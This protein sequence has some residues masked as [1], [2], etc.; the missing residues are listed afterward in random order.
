MKKIKL[1]S[2]LTFFSIIYA[3][4]YQNPEII[5][6]TICGN[7]D[8][9]KKECTPTNINMQNFIGQ[10]ALMHSCIHNS[11]DIFTFLMKNNVD[12]NIKDKAGKTALDYAIKH[13]RP[14]MIEFLYLS[15]ANTNLSLDEALK[16]AA[17]IQ[18]IN[19]QK[20]NWFNEI[21]KRAPNINVL[22]ACLAGDYDVNAR[23]DKGKTALIIAATNGH[24]EICQ[25]LLAAGADVNARDENG[26]S[27]LRWATHNEYTEIVNLLIHS[28]ANHSGIPSLRMLKYLEPNLFKALVCCYGIL[29]VYSLWQS[30]YKE[31]LIKFSMLKEIIEI[32]ADKNRHYD[33]HLD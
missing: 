15:G 10:T 14:E 23:D 6:A 4:N 1:L 30:F 16:K 32:L 13:N 19:N 29:K 28:G 26:N 24:T 3:G 33:I 18:N 11:G 20:Q 8:E 25:L 22:L 9:V 12:F 7:L 5:V 27:A 21:N 31:K 17:E 2:C